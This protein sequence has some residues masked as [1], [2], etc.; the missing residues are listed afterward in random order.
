MDGI[1]YAPAPDGN[2]C[3]TLYLDVIPCALRH[4]VTL[5]R[6]GI[7]QYEGAVLDKIPDT[8]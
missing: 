6:H 5:R 8:A 7:L 1:I 2:L 4:A 3:Q